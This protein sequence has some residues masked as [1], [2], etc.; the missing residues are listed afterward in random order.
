MENNLFLAWAAGFFDGEGSV[1]IELSKSEKCKA[2][3]RTSLHATVT[4]TSLPCLHKFE[5]TFG[6]SIKTY[7][8]TCPNSTRW[9]VQYTWSARNE[10]AIEFLKAIR[11]YAVVKAD[12]IDTALEYPMYSPD[13]R[14]YGNKSN[15]IPSDVWGK[16][17]DLRLKL[18]D[19]RANMKTKAEDR[20][21]Q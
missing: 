9:A 11:P 17:L 8:H 19:I 13:G 12:Q 3:Y 14:K 1:I 4:Q 2:G 18:Q 16:R 15:P 5:E 20:R 7:Q 6:G 10:K 21:G